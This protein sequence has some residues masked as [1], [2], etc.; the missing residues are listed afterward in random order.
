VA[1]LL[2]LTIPMATMAQRTIGEPEAPM[3]L[4][5][6]A[7]DPVCPE[8]QPPPTPT[9]IPPP[10]PSTEPTPSPIPTPTPTPSPYKPPGIDISKWD[11]SVPFDKVARGGIKFGFSKATQGL[12][13][14]DATFAEHNAEGLAAGLAMGAYHFFDYRLDGAAQADFFV[15]TVLANGGFDGMLPP[16]IDVECYNAFGVSDPPYAT[17]QIQAFVSQVFL[18]T[19]R[20]PAIYTSGYMWRRVTGSSTAFADYPLWVACWSCFKPGM[21]GGWAT[22]TF[23]QDGPMRI[24]GVGR[25]FDGNVFN[26]LDEGVPLLKASTRLIANGAPYLTTSSVTLDLNGRDGLAYRVSTD[27]VSWSKLAPYPVGGTV[28]M[29]LGPDGPKTI[30]V[31][32]QDPYGNLSPASAEAVTVDTTAPRVDVPQ[33]AF[34][35]GP[36]ANLA[37]MTPLRV[38]WSA[39]DDTS[40]LQSAQLA[41][42]C[43]GSAVSQTMPAG[44]TAQ[45]LEVELR[46]GAR[47]EGVD[48]SAT[49]NAGHTAT[50]LSI[51]FGLQRREQTTGAI[52]WA[53]TWTKSKAAEFSGGSARS[54]AKKNARATLAFSGSDIAIST[55]R[56]PNRGRF[57]V[58]IDGVAVGTVDLYN[59]T[60]VSRQVVFASHLAT[61]G[62][63]TLTI[64]VLGSRNPQSGGKRVD[65]DAFLVLTP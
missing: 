3:G 33:T 60:S 37:G 64:K 10:T 17:A 32:L 35:L 7:A 30:M 16:V 39:A 54:S 53:G 63:H 31:Q 45:T 59:T 13:I 41:G 19:G 52:T 62:P 58:L 4:S 18:R 25:R 20:M 56:G 57:A 26:G 2:L 28:G 22:W 5:A 34:R 47:C 14:Q 21:F 1:A 49:D 9:P 51:S 38:A 27:G 29:E 40:G 36:Q 12:T 42:V 48:A 61:T 8:T 50:G 24:K 65:V 44:T 6:G 11:G 43:D 15:D 55:T 46:P 23:W